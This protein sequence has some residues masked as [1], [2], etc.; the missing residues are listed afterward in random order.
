MKNILKKVNPYQH[1]LK[2]EV[3]FAG[4]GLH[5]GKP[6]NMVIKPARPDS[7]IRFIRTDINQEMSILAFMDRVVDT[8]LATTIAEKDIAISTT[9]HLLA[10]FA[11]MGIDNAIVELDGAEVPIMDGSAGPFVHIFKRIDRK[12]QKAYRKILKITKEI[13]VQDGD[14]MI[15]IMPYNGMKISCDIDFNHDCIQRQAYTFEVSPKKFIKEIATARTFGFLDEVEKLRENGFALG[16]SL[17][18]A[19]VVDKLG[20]LNEGGLRFADEFVRHKILDLI[21]D[22][23]LLGYPL[24]GHVVASKSGHGQHL[25]LMKQIAAHPDCWEFVKFEKSKDGVLAKVVTTTRATTKAA[26]DMLAP[27]IIPPPAPTLAPVQ[28]RTAY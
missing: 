20:V 27:L 17:D 2:R 21:G 5:S 24:L 23:A 26:G 1:T 3:A 10:T 8:R 14:K 6:V 16:G 28:S 4:I 12:C 25:E 7:G 15:R 11:G 18:N 13:S 22:L 19:V 9:E